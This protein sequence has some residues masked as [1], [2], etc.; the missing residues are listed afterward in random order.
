MFCDL[1]EKRLFPSVWA[2]EYLKVYSPDNPD[3]AYMQKSLGDVEKLDAQH[4][5]RLQTLYSKTFDE[6]EPDEFINK[7]QD[8]LARAK[9]I[10]TE[11]FRSQLEPLLKQTDANVSKV[12]DFIQ[13]QLSSLK[14]TQRRN[15]LE[16]QLKNVD[17]EIGRY[18]D[19]GLNLLFSNFMPTAL[20]T[21]YEA[22]L[23]EDFKVDK[24]FI[25]RYKN[26]LAIEDAQNEESILANEK[27]L[28]KTLEVADYLKAKVEDLSKVMEE[29]RKLLKLYYE[30]IEHYSVNEFLDE[31]KP[32]WQEKA[33]WLIARHRWLPDTSDEEW[34][35]RL[36]TDR[37]W[38]SL[39][40]NP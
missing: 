33:Q 40:R 6:F 19:P 39:P 29:N 5:Q 2:Q 13:K 21:H 11:K 12:K 35:H 24:N 7:A 10:S 32:K 4:Q 16:T 1:V 20:K 8:Y 31:V 15:L 26:D 36:A 17:F 9:E 3:Y 28:Q 25:A 18:G 38:W 23:F 30:D 22:R 27:S 14:D 37:A 34:K